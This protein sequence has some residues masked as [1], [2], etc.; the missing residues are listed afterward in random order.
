MTYLPLPEPGQTPLRVLTIAGSDSGGGAGI[1]ADLRTFTM[2]GVHGLVAVAAVTVQNSVGVSGFHEIPVQVVADQIVAV[3]SDIGLQA[4]KTG[5]LASS[6]IIETVAET[7]RGQGIGT[8]VPLV[9][10]PVCASMHGDPLLHMSALD[11]LRTKLFPIATLVTPN[12]DEVRLLVGVDVVDEASQREAAKALHALG[13]KWVLVKGGHLRSA[14]HSPD[15]LFDGAEF[16]RFDAPRVDT[17]HDH[18]AG[19]TLAAAT[20]AALA[21]G[22]SVPEAV[23][24]AKRWITECLRAAYPLGRGHGPVNPMFRLRG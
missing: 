7:A 3:A 10:D 4:A 19:D 9:V 17:G 21:H 23:E 6:E 8:A 14:P 12:L 1:Q 2:L 13:P 24:F 11:A 16:H 5:M 15:L 18:G 22:H 20:A